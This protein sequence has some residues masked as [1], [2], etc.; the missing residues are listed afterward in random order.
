MVSLLC[1]LAQS[2]EQ[3]WY[4]S[5]QNQGM[6]GWEDA[7]LS[8][9]PRISTQ[10]LGWKELHPQWWETC[11]LLSVVSCER[12]DWWQSWFHGAWNLEGIGNAFWSWTNPRESSLG[13]TTC[14]CQTTSVAQADGCQEAWPSGGDQKPLEGKWMEQ[15]GLLPGSIRKVCG[16]VLQLRVGLSDRMPVMKQEGRWGEGGGWQDAPQP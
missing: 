12:V 1:S 8:W 2:L 3:V 10:W 5:W 14:L 4:G 6:E 15:A 11:P 9:C 7:F 13:S 16:E